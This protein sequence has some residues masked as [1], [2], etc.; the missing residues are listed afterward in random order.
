MGIG[1]DP[2]YNKSPCFDPFP[3]PAEVGEPLKDKIRTEAEALD[4]LRKRVLESHED[5]T[6]TKLY[7]VLEALRE[8]R[9]RHA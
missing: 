8:G 6:L 1:D 2:R 4:A 7:N 9:A 3:F 5:L